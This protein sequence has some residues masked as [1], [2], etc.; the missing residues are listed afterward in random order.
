MKKTWTFQNSRQK[1]KVGNE[2]PWYAGWIEDGNRRSKKVGSRYLAR[3]VANQIAGDL[4]KG[5]PIGDPRIPAHVV[6]RHNGFAYFVEA[7]GLNAV[8]IGSAVD[9]ERRVTQ[10]QVGC[11]AELRP[12]FWQEGGEVREL[13]LHREF[14]GLHIRGDWFRKE[15]PLAD[16]IAQQESEL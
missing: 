15:G 8:K 2:A 10:L 11:P 4:N 3:K 13:E 14:A 16:Y 12:L 9:V 6:R 1:Q 7:M 5:L